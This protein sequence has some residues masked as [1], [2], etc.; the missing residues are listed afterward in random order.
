MVLAELGKS[1]DS[2]I[3]EIDVIK[4]LTNLTIRDLKSCIDDEFGLM[5]AGIKE[6]GSRNRFSALYVRDLAVSAQEAL[7]N[8]DNELASV[9]IP[10]VICGLDLAVLHIGTKNNPETN[11][12]N[13][14][15][16]HEVHT[17]NS[18]QGWLAYCE[19]DFPVVTRPDGKKE[20]INYF[21]DDV[22]SEFRNAVYSVVGALNKFRGAEEGSQYAWR[23]W[24]YVLATLEYDLTQGNL[25]SDILI[26]S[27]PPM[28][29]QPNPT[30]KDSLEPFYDENGKPPV[31][32][33]KYLHNNTV[34]LDSLKKTAQM[35]SLLGYEDIS[36]DLK[37]KFQEGVELLHKLFWMPEHG[38]MSPLLDSNNRPIVFIGDDPVDGL[39]RGIF[40]PQHALKMLSRISEPDMDTSWGIRTRSSDS[41]QFPDN[42][43]DYDEDGRR[44]QKGYYQ[45]GSLFAQRTPQAAWGAF[46]YGRYD[47]AQRFIGH[48]IK[49]RLEMGHKELAWVPKDG[50]KIEDYLEHGKPA[51]CDP[52]LWAAASTLMLLELHNGLNKVAKS[53]TLVVA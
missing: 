14:R 32:P 53:K 28:K 29:M 27:D 47:L 46:L 4:F 16:P 34:F 20:M 33:R 39:W 21:A 15:L 30:F 22:N 3:A 2:G 50:S 41:T 13:N 44:T 51:A 5:A 37:D 43:P 6:D 36:A 26:E 49:Y 19:R 23:M 52:M 1:S 40:Y 18:D 12:H 7:P 17:V 38:F 35:A 42:M 8:V 11:E 45:N 31:G 10:A 24:P 48:A 9:V 25:D